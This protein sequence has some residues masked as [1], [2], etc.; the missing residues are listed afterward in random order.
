MCPLR[1]NHQSAWLDLFIF[2]LCDLGKLEQHLFACVPICNV[3]MVLHFSYA[4][5]EWKK[6]IGAKL[7]EQGLRDKL[8]GRYLAFAAVSTTFRRLFSFRC[9]FF[10]ATLPHRQIWWAC[11]C[12]GLAALDSDLL[13]SA[14]LHG[15]PS[16]I[17]EL[18]FCPLK[19]YSFRTLVVCLIPW[20]CLRFMITISL[21][22][23][24]I[25]VS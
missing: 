13:W 6:A 18:L 5:C 23:H 17:A 1:W 21:L 9:I 22:Y 3:T 12:S 14:G 4:S 8:Y 2:I 11:E 16:I 25:E 7:L 20:T 24:L 19:N 15:I 10:G